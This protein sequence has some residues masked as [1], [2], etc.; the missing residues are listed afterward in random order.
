M[1]TCL[2]SQSGQLL[3]S[4]LIVGARCLSWV[5]CCTLM[6]PHS[7]P[8]PP[9]HAQHSPAPQLFKHSLHPWTY[10]APLSHRL[11][12]VACFVMLLVHQVA[13]PLQLL[14]WQELSR[15]SVPQAAASWLDRPAGQSVS[16]PWE[17]RNTVQ[18]PAAIKIKQL[19]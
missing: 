1:L 18:Y 6:M 14:C 12:V 2:R 7:W 10:S 16:A 13:S 19:V 5:S 3:D 8:R 4:K 15:G 11:V 17:V 9:L